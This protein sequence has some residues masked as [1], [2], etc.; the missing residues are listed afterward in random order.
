VLLR[1]PLLIHTIIYLGR[2]SINYPRLHSLGPV[3]GFVRLDGAGAESPIDAPSPKVDGIVFGYMERGYEGLSTEDAFCAVA[4]DDI[5]LDQK[6][7]LVPDKHTDGKWFG[8]NSSTFGDTSAR[9]LLEDIIRENPQQAAK[10]QAVYT[11]YFGTSLES[12]R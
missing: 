6:I 8:P 11:Q 9:S 1:R 10:L 4:V 7:K 2:Y 5:V 12:A 3:T